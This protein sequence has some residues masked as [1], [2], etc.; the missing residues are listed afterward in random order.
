MPSAARSHSSPGRRWSISSGAPKAL[1]CAG[2]APRARDEQG[3]SSSAGAGTARGARKLGRWLTRWWFRTPD[4]RVYQCRRCACENVIRPGERT[5]ADIDGG[6]GEAGSLPGGP[7]RCGM[8]IGCASSTGL[9][10]RD[11]R[12]RVTSA[13]PVSDRD[14]DAEILALRHQVTVLERQLGRTR[15]RFSPR[16]GAPAALLHRLPRD[17]LGRFR[18]LVR[19]EGTAL[20][21]GSPGALP[22][23]QVPPQAPGPSAHR[24][25]RPPAGAAPGTRE[26]R[27]G[28]SRPQRLSG[29]SP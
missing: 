19:P 17:V 4:G 15:P 7:A 27:L 13:L 2:A 12:V 24:P 26:S 16:P 28:Q 18:L 14:K 3:S 20:A 1:R 5:Y 6:H 23:G 11:K 25:L 22:R 9:S 21:P 29:N 10:R 8:M